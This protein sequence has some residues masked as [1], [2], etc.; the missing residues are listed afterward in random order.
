L[1]VHFQDMGIKQVEVA[2]N[3][4][5]SV[6]EV[7]TMSVLEIGMES[8]SGFGFHKI[9]SYI[10]EVCQLQNFVLILNQNNT[11]CYSNFVF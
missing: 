3:T 9:I 1:Y 7:K 5:D 2:I 4:W 11:L 8:H 6:N 10:I